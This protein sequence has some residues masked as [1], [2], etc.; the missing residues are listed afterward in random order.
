[1]GSLVSAVGTVDYPQSFLR[2]LIDLLAITVLVAA[3]FLRRHGRRDLAVVYVGFNV[4]M[5]AVASVIAVGRVS[6]GVGFGPSPSSLCSVFAARRSRT[7][8]SP[9]SSP[10]SSSV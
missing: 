8:S 4:A 9:T 5:F 3:I 7:S 10:H 6:V 2:L 1:M